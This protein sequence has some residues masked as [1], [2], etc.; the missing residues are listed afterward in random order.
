MRI[1][2]SERFFNEDCVFSPRLMKKESYLIG[3]ETYE[4]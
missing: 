2:L 4:F 3:E 1:A